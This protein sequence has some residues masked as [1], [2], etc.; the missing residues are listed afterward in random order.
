[1]IKFGDICVIIGKDKSGKTLLSKTLAKNLQIDFVYL[2]YNFVNTY[3]LYD[4]Y[5]KNKNKNTV[6]IFDNYVKIKKNQKIDKLFKKNKKFTL[7][8][9]MNYINTFILDVCDIIYINKELNYDMNKHFYEKLKYYFKNF[10][11]NWLTNGMEDLSKFGFLC[12]DKD[13]RFDIKEKYL[14]I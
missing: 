11:L 10:T 13:R 12:F 1:M 4:F 9:V 6:I 2:D 7:I 5:D 14:K 8:Y 3:Y